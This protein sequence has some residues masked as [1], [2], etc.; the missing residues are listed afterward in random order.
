MPLNTW[1]ESVIH[2]GRIGT[3]LGRIGTHLGR[4][5]TP[6]FS[7]L[8]YTHRYIGQNRHPYFW[9]ESV[10]AESV[11]YLA[12]RVIFKYTKVPRYTFDIQYT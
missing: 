12:S 7:A 5:G 10:W 9:A 11:Y 3:H 4:I 8:S 6:N 1:A 2:L